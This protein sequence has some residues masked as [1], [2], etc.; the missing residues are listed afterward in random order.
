MEVDRKRLTL[1]L[2]LYPYHSQIN[3]VN[4]AYQGKVCLAII[5]ITQTR[6]RRLTYVF[7][8]LIKEV[9]NLDAILKKYDIKKGH[10]DISQ[11]IEGVELFLFAIT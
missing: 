10:A 3:N 7:S 8:E 4:N 2:S 6:Q 11:E 1:F 9:I 5:Q